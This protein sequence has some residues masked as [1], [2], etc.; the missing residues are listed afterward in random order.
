MKVIDLLNALDDAGQLNTL[1]QAGCLNIR[2]YNMRDIYQRWQT[3][4]SSLR[5]ADDNGGAVRAVAAELSVSTDTV[6]R[7]VAGMEQRVA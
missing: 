3:L 1:Y 6:Y 4:K 7:A 5:Y 2:A